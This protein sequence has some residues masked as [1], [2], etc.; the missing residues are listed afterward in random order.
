MVD[1]ITEVLD[2]RAELEY[3]AWIE[4]YTDDEE[5]L[6]YWLLELGGDEVGAMRLNELMI[7]VNANDVESMDILWDL[8][9]DTDKIF[10]RKKQEIE[11]RRIQKQNEYGL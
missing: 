4:S 10:N 5:I 6:E 9:A 1:D 11:Q 7:L 8:V 2:S 3:K